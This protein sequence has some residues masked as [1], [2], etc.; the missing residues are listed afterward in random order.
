MPQ[1]YNETR[2]E[3]LKFRAL[4]PD[5]PTDLPTFAKQMDE[6]QGVPGHRAQAYNDGLLKQADAAID[7]AFEATRLPEVGAAAGRFVGGG[8]DTLIGTDKVAPTL[9]AI[10]HDLPRMTAE[11][12]LTLPLG[13]AGAVAKM[14]PLVKNLRRVGQVAGYSDAA[15]SG[16]G[17]TDSLAGGAITAGSMG[18]MN[19]LLL[20]PVTDAAGKEVGLGVGGKAQHAVTEWLKKGIPDIDVAAGSNPLSPIPKVAMLSPLQKTLPEVANI[21]ASAA[22]ATGVNEA[23]RQ[24]ALSVGP[25]AVGPLDSARNPFTPENIVGNI[26]NTLPFAA[27]GAMALHDGFSRPQLSS[28]NTEQLFGDW[29]KNRTAAEEVYRG[30]DW[31]GPMDRKTYQD[32]FGTTENAPAFRGQ[33]QVPVEEYWF[34]DMYDKGIKTLAQIQK[35]RDRFSTLLSTQLAAY[36]Q[37]TQEN[38]QLAAYTKQSI[39]NLLTEPEK[40][41]S[42]PIEAAQVKQ[43][44][45]ELDSTVRM[46]PP[47]DAKGFIKFIADVN[48]FID[49]LNENTHSFAEEQKTKATIGETWHPDA[50]DPSVIQRLQSRDLIEKVTPEWLKKEFAAEFDQSGDPQF[51]YQVVLQKVANR[52][53]NQ[54]PEA[55]LRE[56]ELPPLQSETPLSPKVAEVNRDMG[57]F[58]DALTSLPDEVKDAVLARTKEIFSKGPRIA[59]KGNLAGRLVSTEGSWRKAIIG[60]MK[61]Y[62][63]ESQT[64]LIRKPDGKGF[65]RT[66]IKTLILQD[67][68]GDYVWNPVNSAVKIAE[69]GK[70]TKKVNGK[71]IPEK[72]IQD[73]VKGDDAGAITEMWDEEELKSAIEA[74]QGGTL[75][76]PGELPTKIGV[77][78]GEEKLSPTALGAES[79][80]FL[81]SNNETFKVETFLKKLPKFEKNI[82]ALT[83]EQIYRAVQREFQGTS[84]VGLP[85]EDKLSYYRK[86]GG[87]RAALNAAF[88]FFQNKDDVGPAGR[89]FLELEKSWGRKT[90]PSWGIK[91][92]LDQSLREFFQPKKA[93]EGATIPS[94]RARIG[95]IVDILSDDKTVAKV[96]DAAK[97][98]QSEGDVKELISDNVPPELVEVDKDNKPQIFYHYTR[99]A[100]KLKNELPDLSRTYKTTSW[101][102]NPKAA[103]TITGFSKEKAA[104]FLAHVP[105]YE[106]HTPDI[107]P[108]GVY[109]VLFKKGGN[110]FDYS[111]PEHIGLI[112][113][114]LKAKS[115]SLSAGYLNNL[116]KQMATGDWTVVENHTNLIHDLGFDGFWTWEAGVR[117]IH[118][119]D[120]KFVVGIKEAQALKVPGLDTKNTY[121]NTPTDKAAFA[122]DVYRTVAYNVDKVLSERGYSGTYRKVLT[123]I[124]TALAMQMDGLPA[125]FYSVAGREWGLA[126]VTNKEANVGLKFDTPRVGEEVKWANRLLETLAHEISH[127]DSFILDGLID[128]PDAYSEQRAQHLKNLKAMSE[129]MSPQ[130]RE[131]VLRT[132]K[133]AF[134]PEGYQT[135]VT[136]PKTGRLYGADDPTEFTAVIT[137]YVHQSLLQGKSGGMVKNA[138]EVLD[139]SPTEIREFARGTY[140]TIGD[141]LLGMKESILDSN[142]RKMAGKEYLP[143]TNKFFTSEALHA[144]VNAARE[145]SKLRDA[146]RSLGNA[147]A[148]TAS[149]EG[150]SGI[151]LPPSPATWFR[152]DKELAKV[153][154]GIKVGGLETVKSMPAEVEA[155]NDAYQVLNRKAYD[156][157]M[158]PGLWA[159]WFYPFQ[160]LMF[161]ME[162]SGAP[163]ARPMANL[164]LDLQSRISRTYSQILSAFVKENKDGSFHFDQENALIQRLSTEKNG[165]WRAGGVDRVSQWQ[166]ENGTQ[167]M[168][169][170]DETGTIRVNDQAKGAVEAWD[171]IRKHLT[172]EDQQLVMNA[173][174]ALD[175]TSQTAAARIVATL[176][177]GN[178]I[179]TA[180]L[181][182]AMNKSMPYESALQLANQLVDGFSGKTPVPSVL[183]PDQLQQVQ[184]LLTG[185]NGLLPAFNQVAEKLL[186]RPG[187]RTESLPGDWIVQFHKPNS[188]PNKLSYLSAATEHKA[189]WLA[190]KLE[191]EGNVIVGEIAKKGDLRDYTDFDSPDMLLNKF[192]EVEGAAW[193]KF[194]Q[195]FGQKF[196]TEAQE[197]LGGFTPGA[198]SLKELGTKG[199]GAFLT[200][201]QSK[202][203]RSRYDYIDGTMAWV[204]R[205]AT[206]LEYRTTRQMKDLILADPRAKM[207]PS[208]KKLVEPHFENLMSPTSQLSKE[209]KTFA[210]AYFMGGNLASAVIN[211]TQSVSTLI[212]TLIQLDQSG[213]PVKAYQRL[214]KAVADAV[215]VSA[216]S[217]WESVAKAAEGKDP[218]KWTLE[219]AQAVMYK[220]NI[221]DGGITHGIIQDNIFSGTDQ[222]SLITAKFGHGDY[223]PVT[224]AEMARNSIYLGSQL[225]LKPFGWVEA[226]NNKISLMA[227]V[228][229]GY[230]KGLRGDALYDHAKLVKTLST[231]GGGKSNVPGL[232]PYLSNTYTKSAVGLANTLQQYGYGIVAAYGQLMKDSLGMSPAL[233]A[234]QRRQAQKAFGTMFATQVAL[235]GALGLPFA[236]AS[237]RLL[238]TVFGV[239]ANQLVRQGLAS[240]GSDEDQGAVIAETALNGIGNQ[241]FGLDLSSRMGVS[242]MLGTSSYKGFNLADLAGPTTS[243][244]QNAAQALNLFGQNKPEE[245]FQKLV[246]VAFKN[247]MQMSNTKAKYGEYGFHDAG[248]NLIMKA[249]P[250]EAAMFS[251]GFRPAMLSQKRNAQTALAFENDRALKQQGQELDKVGQALL[252]GDPSQAFQMAQNARYADPTMDPQ[253]MLRRIVNRAV[254]TQTERDLLATGP[255]VN[256]E[257][258]RAI[259]AT[260]PQGTVTRQSEVQREQL[261][262]QLGAQVGLPIDGKRFQKAAMVDLLVQQKGMPR[263]QA[264]RLVEFLHQ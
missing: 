149:L 225:A 153:Y 45:T 171:N 54:I 144:V 86:S 71:T 50:R 157:S 70:P 250:S 5:D 8:L 205:L 27:Q 175:R 251:L 76:K 184:A 178:R 241:M 30:Y 163:L 201:R 84:S 203:D 102:T 140:R 233:D 105:Q 243:I 88:E 262:A 83:D 255:M 245:A 41:G 9:E 20:N 85:T 254:D 46:N 62:D 126:S 192:S 208:F 197:A 231:Y 173:S 63:P 96:K 74:E 160:Q 15:L 260:F 198:T 252:N 247:A 116:A 67:E 34:G 57:L 180:T 193:N 123:D 133:D 61:S 51:S 190:K 189:N 191:S 215:A 111:N 79:P 92:Q 182:M 59:D 107:M 259:A 246:P 212:P 235:G 240:L 136:D 168:F 130:E 147:R 138:L 222:R 19:R 60:A 2:A 12:L 263:S 238:E 218:M 210:T 236:A 119:F 135:N 151:P 106:G 234:Q 87:L 177:L 194:V 223:G 91:K 73:L 199:L 221:A 113:G 227:G 169:V 258:R 108:N 7:R 104:Q 115:P 82:N 196:G 3:Y 172:P 25:N 23:T 31:E 65:E 174:V 155:I 103:E 213:G 230:E 48:S 128:K 66:S 117:N 35:G 229:Q 244:V 22:T 209:L 141:V 58:V 224:K 94:W 166:Q 125:N 69:G 114:E 127:V 188:E 33:D 101:S 121:T 216:S 186:S 256:E 18:L 24:A 56:K 228:A 232:V 95:N 150:A 43:A 11:S 49:Q 53:I 202:V 110:Y 39:V 13:G 93:V 14:A 142:T 143:Y 112:L 159:R 132:M 90:N 257:K 75:L 36:K 89:A 44:L 161:S 204:G 207:F 42:L 253:A 131:A 98:M 183:A 167:S 211:G 185:S 249:T 242:S 129:Q 237:L 52:L 4:N 68:N 146:D 219:E 40:F 64:I 81:K 10:G 214:F 170:Q 97:M 217:S 38:P 264:V 72:N 109:P 99:A 47:E 206:S 28:K 158:R 78:A 226:F 152:T 165:P 122:K 16:Y 156:K 17:D 26:A 162:R 32:T 100:E 37:Q 195:E 6:L 55:L 220:R 21:A 29:M 154:D 80:D 120:K 248:G 200:E 239:P 137:A 134:V 139:Y 124:A 145:G 187:F 164:S 148:L 179:R 1:S 176:D 118:T 181:L 77:A 261:N